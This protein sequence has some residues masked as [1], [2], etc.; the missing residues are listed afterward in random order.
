MVLKFKSAGNGRLSK[1]AAMIDSAANVPGS[2]RSYHTGLGNSPLRLSGARSH[3]APKQTYFVAL[4]LW[5]F[6]SSVC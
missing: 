6:K 4:D 3:K 5:I 1:S 2:P